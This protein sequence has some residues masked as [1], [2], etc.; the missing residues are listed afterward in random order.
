LSNREELMQQVA[1]W[2]TPLS[3]DDGPSGPD[4]E[5]DNA[6]LELSKAAEG[7]PET[8]F[9]K[10]SPPDWRAVRRMAEDLFD[11]TRD[12]R[13]AVMWL[14]AVLGME[15]V[16]GL[17]PGLHLVAS[18]L[19]DHWDHVHPKPDPTDN[20]P[21]ARANALAVLPRMD[22]MLGELMTARIAM[23]KGIGELT[24][25]AADIALGTTAARAGEATHTREAI[26]QMLAAVEKEG[27]PLRA[28]FVAAQQ[29][30]KR[31]MTVLDERF[32]AGSGAE[33]KPL[34][35]LVGR[36]LPLTPEPP[37]EPGEEELTEE[38]VGGTEAG[39]GGRR[40]AGLS[41]SINTRTEAIRAIDMVCEYLERAE[42]TNPAPLFLRRAR[43][44]L[45]RNFLQL[46]KELAPNALDEVA[47]SVGIDPST[48]EPPQ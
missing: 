7:K 40:G 4:L 16:S 26:V 44:L 39:G 42:P 28:D 9:D 32:G 20:D 19:A 27:V 3:G 14:R 34:A 24:M 1:A 12:L 35:D 11:R 30:V 33:L 25:R 15:G 45:E 31:L 8:Q 2:L 23:I 5:Y 38:G 21:Y 41:G 47:R 43:S 17:G 13:M 10:G 18:L 22:G 46:L 6:F 37:P 36:V 48:V 29:E